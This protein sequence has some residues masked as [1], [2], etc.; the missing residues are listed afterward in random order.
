MLWVVDTKTEAGERLAPIPTWLQPYLRQLVEGK[1]RDA[2][3]WDYARNG[4]GRSTAKVL[5]ALRAAGKPLT[6]AQIAAASGVDV[7]VVY[8]VCLRLARSGV[9]GRPRRGQYEHRPEVVTSALAMRR[10]PRTQAP[11]RGWVT[12]SVKRICGAAGLPEVTAQGNRGLWGTLRM[13]GGF[14]ALLAETAKGLGHADQGRV[15]QAHYIDPTAG[16]VAAQQAVDS[17]LSPVAN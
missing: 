1:K 8:T 13:V 11:D 9:L 16:G 14:D 2:S 6:N 3:L 12:D 17:I 10:E 5:E 15:A 7:D 4:A